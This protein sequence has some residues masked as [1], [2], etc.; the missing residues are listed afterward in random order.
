M[1]RT[2]TWDGLERRSGIDRRDGEERRTESRDIWERRSGLDRRGHKLYTAAINPSP[3]PERVEDS[4]R[5][6]TG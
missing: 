5:S 3:T 1:T 2:N 4:R 6:G